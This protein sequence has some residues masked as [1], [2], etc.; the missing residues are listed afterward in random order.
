MKEFKTYPVGSFLRDD[1]Y[2]RDLDFVIECD[3][4]N[5]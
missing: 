4:K 2:L 5:V 3:E 1:I